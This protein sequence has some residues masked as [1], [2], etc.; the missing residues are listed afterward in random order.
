MP[1]VNVEYGMSVSG[2]S[3]QFRVHLNFFPCQCSSCLNG[4]VSCIADYI[5]ADDKHLTDTQTQQ[6]KDELIQFY[7][8]QYR[9]NSHDH[10]IDVRLIQQYPK[11]SKPCLYTTQSIVPEP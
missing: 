9:S 11:T 7:D 4:T 1:Q 8:V 3:L 2:S 6:L 10:L 5:P